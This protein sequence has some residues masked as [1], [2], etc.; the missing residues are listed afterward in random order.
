MRQLH[1]LRLSR[2]TRG[3]Q[4]Q[5]DRFGIGLMVRGIWVVGQKIADRDYPRRLVCR[6]LPGL[7]DD[8]WLVECAPGRC[9]LLGAANRVRGHRHR[10]DAA[11]ET[12]PDRRH[13]LVVAGQVNNRQISWNKSRGP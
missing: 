8:Q 12:S 3:Q 10:H 1:T 4:E 11:E 9:R 13:K 2:A 6:R 7:V 5:C